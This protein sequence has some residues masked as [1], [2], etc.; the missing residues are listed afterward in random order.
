MR[1]AFVTANYPPDLGGIQVVVSELAR[2][3]VRAGNEVEVFAHAT[4]LSEPGTRQM[5]GVVVRRFRVPVP[6][7]DFEISPPLMA[8]LVRR[9][10][11]FD[12]VHAH[13]FHA[14]PA[15]MAAVARMR[16]LVFTPHYHGG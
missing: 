7:R 10:H 8:E 12:V 1:I 15:L 2:Q 11:D 4:R 13:N 16:P 9:R 3:M 5:D 14:L 6:S